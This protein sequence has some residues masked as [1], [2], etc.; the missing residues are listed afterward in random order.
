MVE[1][2][3]M[4]SNIEAWEKPGKKCNMTGNLLT[5][6]N[7]KNVWEMSTWMTMGATVR[8]ARKICIWVLDQLYALRAAPTEHKDS[9]AS[10]G[11]PNMEYVASLLVPEVYGFLQEQFLYS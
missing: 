3:D 6:Y 10:S 8:S 4:G 7:V 11:G 1:Y 9:L 2:N 5:L